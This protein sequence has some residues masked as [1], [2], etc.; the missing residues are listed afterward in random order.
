MDLP[1]AVPDP[2]QPVQAV[3]LKNELSLDSDRVRSSATQDPQTL[4]PQ[5]NGGLLY[6]NLIPG[7]YR[8]GAK[9]PAPPPGPLS[10]ESSQYRSSLTGALPQNTNSYSNIQD[11][12]SQPL[13][14][15]VLQVSE[16]DEEDDDDDLLVIDLDEDADDDERLYKPFRLSASNGSLHIKS[17]RSASSSQSKESKNKAKKTQ[18]VETKPIDLLAVLLSGSLHENSPTNPSFGISNLI[19]EATVKSRKARSMTTTL[20]SRDSQQTSEKNSSDLYVDTSNAHTEAALAFQKVYR[21]L[22]GIEDSGTSLQVSIDGLSPSEELAKSMLI[23]ANGHAKM[24]ASLKDMGV[25]WNMGKA[26]SFGVARPIN[27]NSISAAASALETQTTS[28]DKK[29]MA[30][31]ERIRLAVR[32]ALDT[33]NHEAD[34]S[35]STFLARSAFLHSK[36]AAKSNA[37]GGVMRNGGQTIKENPVDDL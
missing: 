25:K 16:P 37:H 23:L 22:L 29:P 31:H 34:I 13:N 20:A 18:H 8:Y 7:H 19:E 27:N 30:Q 24:A 17:D 2:P 26:E 5:Q 11:Y 4:L 6:N 3:V 32:G 10:V 15:Q 35:N 14:K 28:N 33:G 12:D 21:S 1:F 36:P 9:P